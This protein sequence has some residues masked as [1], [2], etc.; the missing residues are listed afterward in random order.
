MLPAAA[1]ALDLYGSQGSASGGRVVSA[2][3]P[4]IKK[5]MKLKSELCL[6]HNCKRHHSMSCDWTVPDEGGPRPDMEWSVRQQ[7][8]SFCCGCWM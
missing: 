6:S 5:R 4:A 8:R 2:G 3:V 7:V 1:A